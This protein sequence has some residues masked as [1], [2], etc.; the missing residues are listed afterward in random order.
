MADIATPNLPSRSFEA[1]ARF[2]EAL[3][4]GEAYRDAGWLIL[5]RGTLQLEF[6]PFR[7]LNPAESS[8]SCCLRLDDADA[9][10]R[11]CLEAGIPE[12]TRGF[13][14]VHAPKLEDSGLR[15]GALLS[16]DGSLLRLIQNDGEPGRR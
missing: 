16:Q 8:F 12:Q 6:F 7:T 4:F 11:L 2:Y 15:I 9:F 10:F 5:T 1:T 3:G 14:R 13:P